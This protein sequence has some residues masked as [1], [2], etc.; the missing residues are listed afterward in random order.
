MLSISIPLEEG[1][2]SETDEFEVI[3]E[4]KLELEHSL[5][6]LSKWE[7]IHEK[8]FLGSKDLTAEEM[9]D[10]IKVMSLLPEV[11]EEVWT[12]LTDQNVTEI[13][14][15]INKKMTATWFSDTPGNGSR[16][17][18][19]AELIYY[20][21]FSFGIPKECENWHLSKLFT[22]IRVH[23]VKNAPEKKMTRAERFA[24]QRRLNEQR[25]AAAGSKG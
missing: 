17:T 10:Y 18:I 5:V 21:M 1:F 3:R 24:Q 2:N 9:F 11:P 6:S 12:H 15:Y 20:W 22:Q 4:F 8:P 14:E 7:Q 16:E 23:S 25:R 19:T 13:S